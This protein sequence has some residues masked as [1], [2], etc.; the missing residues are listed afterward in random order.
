M[1]RRHSLRGAVAVLGGLILLGSAMHGDQTPLATPPARPAAQVRLTKSE[2]AAFARDARK[3]VDVE[4][5]AGIEL[6]LWASE[7]LISD[8][9]AIEV[10]PEGT[11]YVISSSRA[12]LPLDI[13]GHADWLPSVHTLTTNEALREFYR[14]DLATERSARNTWILDLNKDGSH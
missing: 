4:M 3:G 12:D 5:P 1:N 10:D 7:K 14:K 9:V 2:A 13:R 6:T 11:A 8:P